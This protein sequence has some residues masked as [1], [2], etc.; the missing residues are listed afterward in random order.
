LLRLV[1]WDHARLTLFVDSSSNMPR[2]RRYFLRPALQ[3]LAL[4]C[5]VQGCRSDSPGNPLPPASTIT[6]A[7]F[8]YGPFDSA[9]HRRLRAASDGPSRSHSGKP[10]SSVSNS[11]IPCRPCERIAAL[12]DAERLEESLVIAIA[13][14]VV[15]SVVPVV[16]RVVDQAVVGGARKTSHDAQVGAKC[17]LE[18]RKMNCQQ[19]FPYPRHRRRSPGGRSPW[20]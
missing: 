10:S 19:L 6:G 7:E 18:S 5:A 9:R 17:E 2:S 1:S 13:G 3:V 8:V 20:P 12:G 15:G 16:H 11:P 14:E 4:A